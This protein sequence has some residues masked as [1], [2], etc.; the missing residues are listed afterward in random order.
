VASGTDPGRPE[1]PN[2][3]TPAV[4]NALRPILS[5]LNDSPVAMKL[6]QSA[7]VDALPDRPKLLVG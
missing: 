3:K 4:D 7:A 6:D 2:I 1:I 5:Q